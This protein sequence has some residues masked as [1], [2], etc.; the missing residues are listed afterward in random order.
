MEKLCVGIQILQFF[1]FW[2]M[3]PQILNNVKCNSS[4][5]NWCYIVNKRTTKNFL[6]TKPTCI[7][8]IFWLFNSKYKTVLY[9]IIKQC[10]W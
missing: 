5:I 2:E 1:F 7:D 10:Y 4:K 9:Y 3:V 6:I 8:Y